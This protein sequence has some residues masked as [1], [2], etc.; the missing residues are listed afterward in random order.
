MGQA[1]FVF[2][3]QA[4]CKFFWELKLLICGCFEKFPS[5]TEWLAL[6]SIYSG[7]FYGHGYSKPPHPIRREG[8]LLFAFQIVFAFLK[9][10]LEV[11]SLVAVKQWDCVNFNQFRTSLANP[12]NYTLQRLGRG[13][14][15]GKKALPAVSL[16]SFEKHG[17]FLTFLFFNQATME[18]SDASKGQVRCIVIMYACIKSGCPICSH[19]YS[20]A[21]KLTWKIENGMN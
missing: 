15:L 1:R 5:A 14:Q 17:D 19:Y 6:S 2:V 3:F 21:W 12:N 13:Q 11:G 4:S 9:Y 16:W 18:F 8:R 10:H 7:G 20:L